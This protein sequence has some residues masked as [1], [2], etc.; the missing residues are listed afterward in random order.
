MLLL[1]LSSQVTIKHLMRMLN[2]G[3]CYK[4]NANFIPQLLCL[5]NQI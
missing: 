4:I 3:Y 2:L 1:S 5:K